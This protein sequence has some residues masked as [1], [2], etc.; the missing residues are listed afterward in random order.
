M[1]HT[2]IVRSPRGWLDPFGLFVY[3]KNAKVTINSEKVTI[4]LRKVTITAEKVT[5]T[6]NGPLKWQ[7]FF[8]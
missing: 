5:I 6:R 2:I 4:P 3:E 1:H 8:G 7:N